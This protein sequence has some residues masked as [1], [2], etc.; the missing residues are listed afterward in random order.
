[1]LLPVY[2]LAVVAAALAF[3][4]CAARQPRTPCDCTEPCAAAGGAN[5]IADH[6]RQCGESS[7]GIP[8]GCNLGLGRLHALLHGVHHEGYP[9]PVEPSPTPPTWT[10]FHPV[11]TRPVFEPAPYFAPAIYGEPLPALP[12]P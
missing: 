4:G 6:C 12:A 3:V 1:M 2:R 11:P 5:S 7:A 8:Q 10:R 9:K